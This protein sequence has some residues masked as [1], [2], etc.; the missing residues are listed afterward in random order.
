MFVLK[1]LVPKLLIQELYVGFKTLC[2]SRTIDSLALGS[3]T[4]NLKLL[5]PEIL[6][7]RH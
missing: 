6:V 4:L 2:S 3:Q 1:L 5:I 7:P